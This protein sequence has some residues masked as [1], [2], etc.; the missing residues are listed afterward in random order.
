MQLSFAASA[1]QTDSLSVC[2]A[3]ARIE[4]KLAAC[5]CDRDKAIV[6]GDIEYAW[7]AAVDREQGRVGRRVDVQ[8]RRSD[9]FV[10]PGPGTIYLAVTEHD[11]I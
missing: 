5:F 4:A 3:K 1:Q 2:R 9:G 7:F 11:A 8:R 6:L 10:A